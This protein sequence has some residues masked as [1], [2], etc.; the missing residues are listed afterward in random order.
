V[1]ITET[2]H[3]DQVFRKS[4]GKLVASLVNRYGLDEL[5]SIENAIMEAY[6]KAMKMFPYEGMP[7]HIE[8]WLYTVSKNKLIDEFRKKHREKLEFSEELIHVSDDSYLEEQQKFGDAELQLLFTICHP[9]LKPQDQLAFMLKTIAGFGRQEIAAALLSSEEKI[10]KRL[11]RARSSL[12]NNKVQFEI[13]NDTEILKRRNVVH[14][15]LYL[16]FNEG[17]YSNHKEYWVRKDMCLEAMRLCKILSSHNTAN[18]DTMALMAIMCYHVARL[19]SRIDDNGQPVAL[20]YQDR[21]KWNPFFINLGDYYLDLSIQLPD[22]K[23]EFQL[24]AAIG[25]A[26]CHAKTFAATKWD[27]ILIL[28]KRLYEFKPQ[29]QILLSQVAVYLNMGKVQDAKELYETLAEEQ[30]INDKANYYLV[31]VEMYKS[32]QENAEHSLLIQKMMDAIE[33]H[34]Q[35]KWKNHLFENL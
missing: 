12:R 16:L 20:E 17:Y 23:T 32:L 31:G 34:D 11:S 13:P 15:S 4:Y 8:A 25:A 22:H 26:H 5:D 9:V 30:F 27:Y 7:D 21:T 19:E 2:A 1:S 33:H 3:I 18:H 28:Y 14:R 6:Y 10:K 24:E 35:K 29:V